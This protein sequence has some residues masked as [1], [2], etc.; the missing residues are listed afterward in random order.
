MW[1]RLVSAI[2]VALILA[3]AAWALWPRPTAVEIVTIANRDLQV[4]VEEEGTSRIREVFRVSAPVGGSLTRVTVHAGDV[5]TEGQAVASIR[6]V[7]P[8]LLDDRSRR[9]AQAT[10]EAAASAVDLAAANLAQ[11]EAQRDFA[12]AELERTLTLADRGLVPAR[13]EQQVVLEASTAE[14]NVS[15]ARATLLMRQ[16]EFERAQA[17][18]IEGDGDTEASVCCVEVRAPAS[19][20]VLS[21][22]TESAQVV[23]PG[24]P[25][26]DIGDPGDLEVVIE[27]LSSD[28]VRIS[29]G[30]TATIEGWGGEPLAARVTRIEPTA[31]TRISA[32]G[33][34]EQRTKVTL[35]FTDEPGK[36]QR[37]GHGFHVIAKVVVW[38]GHSLVTVPMGSLF[39]HGDQWAVFVVEDGVA[40]VRVVTLGERNPDYAVVE[41]GLAP[42]EVVILHPGD[43]I[44]DGVRVVAPP[45]T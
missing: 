24:T 42:N 17:S 10:A 43:T 13:I 2:V 6:P 44:T 39:R 37:L 45:D 4:L 38:E 26:L 35:A 34:E 9:I 11:A 8:G 3:S 29:E 7:A 12:A 40:T 22:L 16:Q 31:T 19:G 28:A 21:V 27:V 33:I 5:V 30:A 20:Q 23:Q 14:S 32:L 1:G 18:L 41:S 25:L 15:A 36:R